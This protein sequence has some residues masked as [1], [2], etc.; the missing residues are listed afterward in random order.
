M[1]RANLGRSTFYAHL[2]NKDD[3]LLSGFADLRL[4]FEKHQREIAAGQVRDGR[5]LRDM[6]LFWFQHVQSDRRVCKALMGAPGTGVVRDRAGAFLPK[7]LF[8]FVREQME[9]R[10]QREK[11]GSVL[12]EIVV[13]YVAGSLLALTTWWL[14]HN[15]PFRPKK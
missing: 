5:W 14:D 11:Y 12:S 7:F 13:H 10:M 8:T 3:I 9:M 6:G 15:M 1:D 4:A 2:R